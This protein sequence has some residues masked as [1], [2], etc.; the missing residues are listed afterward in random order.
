[1]N[2][3]GI[4]KA[5]L[6]HFW[7]RAKSLFLTKINVEPETQTIYQYDCP[8]VSDLS[9]DAPSSSYLLSPS[10]IE[11]TMVF[12]ISPGPND[13]WCLHADNA[14][15]AAGLTE[16]IKLLTTCDV[17]VEIISLASNITAEYSWTME[18]HNVSDEHIL[19]RDDEHHAHI[20]IHNDMI[21]ID[22]TQD[23]LTLLETMEPGADFSEIPS[24][25]MLE[26]LMSNVPISALPI[27]SK[28]HI[29]G[30]IPSDTVASLSVQNLTT[31]QAP[32]FDGDVVNKKYFDNSMLHPKV[33]VQINGN[34]YKEEMTWR[35]IPRTDTPNNLL[36]SLAGFYNYHSRRTPFMPWSE[37]EKYV[38]V[39]VPSGSKDSYSTLIIVQAGEYLMPNEITGIQDLKFVPN[40]DSYSD[41][42]VMLP[43]LLTH[44]DS[45]SV[46]D[47]ESSIDD[48]G[49]I[50]SFDGAVLNIKPTT[51]VGTFSEKPI[52]R[53][54]IGI[55]E[56]FPSLQDLVPKQRTIK[57]PLNVNLVIPGSIQHIG[58]DAL[59][60]LNRIRSIEFAETIQNNVEFFDDSPSPR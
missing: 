27:L 54:P 31:N 2:E 25:E 29:T 34:L 48:F 11:P 55:V 52:K 5:G 4:N 8:L 39:Y 37:Y 45:I 33:P 26:E 22:Y 40:G 19:L 10:L 1:M 28:L 59:R 35:M 60:N 17:T 46:V 9:L 21:S 15:H 41:C 43:A 23:M 49:P 13:T 24:T 58:D 57:N 56:K 42:H 50:S 18:C 7:N 36:P 6:K 20:T 30:A 12:K 44:L 3:K 53:E 47:K 32:M 51:S 14:V 38:S 16:K